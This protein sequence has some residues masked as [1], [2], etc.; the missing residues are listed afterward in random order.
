MEELIKKYEE[1]LNFL[2]E[3]L[4]TAMYIGENQ[5][6]RIN[7]EIEVYTKIVHDLRSFLNFK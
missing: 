7:S 1:E 4:D 3:R 5:K 2:N 6:I